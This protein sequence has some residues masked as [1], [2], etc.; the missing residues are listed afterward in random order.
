MR[1][2]LLCLLLMLCLAK[3]K[4]NAIEGPESAGCGGKTAQQCVDL[5]LEAMGGRGRLQQI[6]SVRLRTIGHTALAEQS[7]RQEP[8][9]TSYESGETTI[10]LANQRVLREAK[11]TWP[12]SD[13][14][15]SEV[16]ST[17]VLGPD[18]CV[19]RTKGGDAPCAP[20]NVHA[21]REMLA[22]GPERLLL[23]ASGAA[24]LR[25]EKPEMLRSTPHAVVAFSWQKIPVKVLLNPFNHLPDAVETTQEFPDF[26]FFWGDVRQR[27]YWDNWQLLHGVVYPTNRVEE[28]NGVLWSS[29]QVLNV[30]LNVPIDDK[31]FAM[32]TNMAK[33]SFAS[34]GWKRAFH[35]DKSTS[36]AAGVDLF[37]GAW[38]STIVKQS[39]GVVILEAPISSTYAQG[40]IEEARKRYPGA[41]IKAVLSTSD[42]WPHAGGVRYAV[43]EGL[44]VYIL[45]L[46][47]P[48]LDRMM[49]APHTLD[50]DA[51]E[52][53]KG[54]QPKWKIVG[55]KEEIGSGDNRVELYPIR[56]A[57]TERQ[58]MVYFPQ[59]HLLYASDTLVVNDDGS[60][61]AP[62]LMREVAQA[63]KREGLKVETVFAMHQGP[64]PWEQ[65][66]KQLEKAAQP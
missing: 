9:I 39:D 24:D 51:L 62:E 1:R 64:T 2:V 13:P 12:E 33:R 41:P 17:W 60:L 30:E 46:N 47:R 21:A 32:D 25:L 18:G 26:W 61:Y 16:E 37:L 6:T 28:R 38:N 55:A 22:L 3:S 40:V 34:P 45:D 36:L 11:L 56:G 42:S 7:Y 43:A 5:A 35:G 20:G 54:K 15:Q 49:S 19:T 66:V 59:A 4:S 53:S 48:L 31:A 44:P 57:C 27:V 63:V 58:Y 10:D 52:A 8:F 65:V 23:A 50:P 14:N 29:A